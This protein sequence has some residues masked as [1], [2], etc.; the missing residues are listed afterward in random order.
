MVNF[1][2]HVYVYGFGDAPRL[3]GRFNG[4]RLPEDDRLLGL[5]SN[6]K[7]DPLVVSSATDRDL[8][9]A[10]AKGSAAELDSPAP[11]LAP[12]FATPSAT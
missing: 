8:P 4:R 7:E 6:N 9:L 2:S 5:S 1:P 12:S 10:G 3:T 11:S